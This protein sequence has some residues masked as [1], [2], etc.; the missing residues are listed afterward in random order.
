MSWSIHFIYR[1][2]AKKKSKKKESETNKKRKFVL[3]KQ[4]EMFAFFFLICSTLKS[5]KEKRRKRTDCNFNWR[6]PACLAFDLHSNAFFSKS[7]RAIRI[8]IQ[9][10]LCSTMEID[11]KRFNRKR[12]IFLTK[13]DW[14]HFKLIECNRTQINSSQFKSIKLPEMG[15][16]YE[17]E[18]NLFKMLAVS[19]KL[20]AS[21]RISK[22]VCVCVDRE[23]R[24]EMTDICDQS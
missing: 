19:F 11:F 24:P 7:V 2:I 4:V 3:N 17:G 10:G 14:F 5:K 20:M 12:S 21:N 16:K 1:T 8:Q 22:C 6:K 9:Q 18:R 15:Y 23:C 13:R